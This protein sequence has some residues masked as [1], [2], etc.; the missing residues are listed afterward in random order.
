MDMKD[1]EQF[2]KNLK[3]EQQ[4]ELIERLKM[5]NLATKINT[6]KEFL[7]EALIELGKE[8]PFLQEYMKDRIY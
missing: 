7:K 8:Y 5:I 2:F 3:T 6:D 4:T 1:L